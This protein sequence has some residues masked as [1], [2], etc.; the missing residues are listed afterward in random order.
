MPAHFSPELDDF[1]R[2]LEYLSLGNSSVG[3]KYRGPHKTK[4]DVPLG[5]WRNM[6]DTG[7]ILSPGVGD[8]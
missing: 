5:N 4:W 3:G 6:A 8:S 1:Q 2:P 7:S